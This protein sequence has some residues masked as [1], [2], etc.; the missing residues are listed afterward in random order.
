MDEIH[1]ESL[2]ADQAELPIQGCRGTL[3]DFHF[4]LLELVS[5]TVN[6]TLDL[7]LLHCYHYYHKTNDSHTV[8]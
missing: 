2:I 5:Q 3:I 4:H 1:Q 7:E 6:L 8:R